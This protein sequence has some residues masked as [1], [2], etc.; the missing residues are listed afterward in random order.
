MNRTAVNYDPFATGELSRV[1]PTTESQ[2]ELWLASYEGDEAS[3]AFNE[4]LCLRLRGALDL[5]ALE[6][7]LQDLVARHDALRASF[8]PDGEVF[9][10]HQ[11]SSFSLS[12][13]DLSGLASADR[14]AQVQRSLRHAVDTPFVFASGQMFVADLLRLGAQDHLLVMSGHHIVVDGW[15]WWVMLRELGVLYTQ[16]HE[17][18]AVSLPPVQSYAD[19]A[20]EEIARADSAESRADEAYWISRFADSVPVLQLPTDR[21]RPA[22]RG[23]AS[24]REDLVLDAP[25]L[26]AIRRTG[27]KRGASLFATLLGSFAGLL[28]RLTG[29][30][31]VVI[32]I[33]AAGQSVDGQDQLVGHCV[34][35]LS[36]RFRMEPSL[37]FAGLLQ[38]SQETLLD[39]LDHQRYTFGT[40]LK[41]LKLG[42]DPGRLPLVSVMFNIDQALE[43]EKNGFEGLEVELATNPRTHENFELFVNAVQ[44]NG[45]LRLEC[46][47]NSD[48]FDAAT[49]QRWLSSYESLLRA[50]VVDTEIAVGQLPLLDDTS[51]TAL[52]AL[53]PEAVAFDRECRMHEHFER[54]CDLGPD[55]IA[56]SSGNESSSY[57]A[58]ESRANRIAHLLRSQGVRSGQ[59]VG[60]AMDRGID[61]LAGLLGILKAGAGYVPLD[62]QFPADRL[63][64][65]A[66]DARLSALLTHQK[67]ASSF[68]LQGQ[69]VLLLDRVGDMLDS[70]PDTRIGRDADAAQPES[71]AYV[72]YT[73]GSTG[74]PKGVQ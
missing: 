54:Q 56:V 50:A 74:R 42:R 16:R 6:T 57:A 64:Y 51:R 4:S 24:L 60:L 59:L 31:D 47:Y 25:L 18:K 71:V 68:D 27:A 15:S 30:G 48:L 67:H 63:Q 33:P 17:G 41:Q 13:K 19:Y 21:P 70:Q 5:T 7:A 37:P 53:Q 34:N 61:M 45:G 49:I 20:L 40:L 38:Q 32:G 14:D 29:Q 28:S 69:P 73:S 55:R 39:A 10:V 43:S 22:V 58:L 46:Q 36:L 9:C 2:R 26:D 65:M 11:A 44:E 12:V 8:G 72:I 66:S 52:A 23:Y 62:P 35:L 3:L 1:V